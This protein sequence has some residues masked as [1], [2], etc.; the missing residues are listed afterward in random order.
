[1]SESGYTGTFTEH[2]GCA[3]IATVSPGTGSG[4]SLTETA[5]GTAAGT[6]LATFTDSAG[7]HAS[8]TIVVTTTSVGISVRVRSK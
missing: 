4:P 8:V 2:D 6:C 3:G 5:M 7:Q 1:M